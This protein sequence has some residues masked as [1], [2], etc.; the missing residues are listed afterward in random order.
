VETRGWTLGDVFVLR[1]AGF[2]FDWLESL[3]VSAGVLAGVARAIETGSPAD[4]GQ[5]EVA[6]EADRQRLRRQ[7]RQLAQHPKVKEA[8]F[9]SSPDMF[10]NVWERYVSST[11]DV[12]NSA[13]RRVERRIYAYLQRLC[14]K[15][16]TTSFFGPMGEGEVGGDDDDDAIAFVPAEVHRKT[17]LAYWAVEALA[18]RAAAEREI[19][20][21][22]P[23]RRNPMFAV[24]RAARE[25]RC[26]SLFRIVPLSSAQIGLLDAV[27]RFERAEDIAASRGEPLA[28]VEAVAMSLF[29]A[30][31]LV[32]RLWFPSDVAD[33][34][35]GLRSALAALPQ[36]AARERWLHNISRLNALR[37][38]FE[39]AELQERR[40]LL[41]KLEDLFV[42][43]TDVPARR[44]GGRLY[45]DRLIVNEEVSS[46]FRLRMGKRFAK[47]L[48]RALS[49]LLE[50]CAA[51]GD[52]YQRRCVEGVRERL[53]SGGEI[54]FL[55]YAASLRDLRVEQPPVPELEASAGPV[56]QLPPALLG[57]SAAGPRFALPDVCLARKGDG[58]VRPILARMHHQLLTRGWLFAFSSN[59]DR[60]ARLAAR[61]LHVA[62]IPLVELATGRHNKGYYSFP[63]PRVAHAIAE[64]LPRGYPVHA[65]ANVNVALGGQAPRL[66]AADGTPLVLYLP[67]ADLTLHAPFAAL[68]S[69]PVIKP[70]LLAEGPHSPRLDIETATYQREGWEL[71]VA[72]WSKLTSF[73]LFQSMQREKRRLGLPR[74]LFA[75][76]ATERKPFLVDTDCPFSVEL[77]R[78][79][80]GTGTVALEEMLPAPEDLWLRDEHGRYTFELRMQAERR[81]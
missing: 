41:R 61:W 35:D 30:G 47:D 43:L 74:F 70:T 16:E 72:G 1:H 40:G 29:Q 26:D 46:P 52:R 22:L 51:H 37:A 21:G 44:A 58:R 3:G 42:E 13:S 8:V 48:E 54:S 7:L 55:S 76:V 31:V 68:A 59:P 9:L 50:L 57:A 53:G 63:G 75:R 15:N 67:L 62:A 45:T 81:E 4:L 71:S 64:M 12:D 49:P 2:P 77:L 6:Y 80:A 28:V 79:H 56:M 38:A 20:P 73:A 27:E 33:T 11:S 39:L 32:R 78:H 66:V 5:A 18:G 24:D 69:A 60:V 14:A 25:A 65:A 34:L 17:S 19:W 36:S 10:E 23:I